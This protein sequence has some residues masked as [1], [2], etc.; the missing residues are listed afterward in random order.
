MND[1]SEL[2]TL[3]YP[4]MRKICESC[5]NKQWGWTAS[6]CDGLIRILTELKGYA[7][8]KEKEAA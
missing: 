1:H 3:L 7:E 2:T 8:R 4:Y 5:R 6:L